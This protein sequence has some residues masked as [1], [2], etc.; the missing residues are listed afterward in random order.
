MI[1]LPDRIP[2]IHLA[3][4]VQVRCEVAW[5]RGRI[6]RAAE[7]SGMHGFWMAEDVARGVVDYLRDHHEGTIIPLEAL[8]AKLRALLR[9]IDFPEVAGHLDLS[10]PPVPV[11]LAQLAD[12]AGPGYEL[13]FFQLLDSRLNLLLGAGAREVR[14]HGLRACVRQLRGASRWRRDCRHLES[15]I[16]G[17]IKARKLV[18]LAGE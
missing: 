2:L 15:E 16:L 11:E 3:E 8:M 13:V 12:L 6:E 14:V 17:H 10:P 5:L 1:S 7:A 4:S 9:R 18:P